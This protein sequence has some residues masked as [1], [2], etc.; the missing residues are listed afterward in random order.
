MSLVSTTSFNTLTWK[1]VNDECVKGTTGYRDLLFNI[2]Q[3]VVEQYQNHKVQ[4]AA[5]DSEN[6]ED[7]EEGSEVIVIEEEEEEVEDI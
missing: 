5:S 3:H 2:L 7:D 4:E 6:S 1:F